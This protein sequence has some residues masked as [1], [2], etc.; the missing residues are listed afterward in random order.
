MKKLLPVVALLCFMVACKSKKKEEA[1]PDTITTTTTTTT[2]IDYSWVPKFA[3]PE[4]Q[5]YVD[6]YTAFMMTYDYTLTD[7][8]K[9]AE[10]ANKEKDWNTGAMPILQKL[11]SNSEELKKWQDW[12][13]EL[14]KRKMPAT[15]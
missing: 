10:Q 11:G 14:G 1:K 6:G 7:S 4:V 12:T 15:K 3:D 8:A 13:I 2:P 5:K 9:A